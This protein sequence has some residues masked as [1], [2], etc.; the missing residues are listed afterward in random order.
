MDWLNILAGLVL[1]ALLVRSS[2]SVSAVASQDQSWIE[3]ID[4]LTLDSRWSWGNEDPTHWSLTDNPGYL[5][6]LTQE[7]SLFTDSYKNLLLTT[8]NLENYHITTK[9]T[10]TPIE[11]VQS[12]SLVVFQDAQNYIQLSRRFGTENEILFRVGI[13]GSILVN[14]NIPETA[15]TVYLRIS[16]LSDF[17]AGAYSLDGNSWTKAGQYYGSFNNPQ[18]GL[19]AGNGPSTMEINADFDYFAMDELETVYVSE[20]GDCGAATPCHPTI[21]GAV[22]ATGD[23][24]AIKVAAGTYDVLNDRPCNDTEKTGT[25]I[26][27]V[28]LDKNLSLKGGYD[29]SDWNVSDPQENPTVL[30]PDGAGRAVYA[31]GEILALLDGLEIRNG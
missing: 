12:A 19:H 24:A 31:S 18:V 25:V 5:R 22:D 3:E 11:G 27:V 15:N 8:P 21:Q 9:V 2:L 7:G 6:I 4:S 23:N 1:I 17:Y 10:F 29:P 28:Y 16:K 13:D 20:D 30:D 26:Q 14:K